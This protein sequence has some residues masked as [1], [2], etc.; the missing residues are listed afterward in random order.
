MTPSS[1]TGGDHERVWPEDLE[2]VTMNVHLTH[3]RHHDAD[4]AGHEGQA[5]VTPRNETMLDRSIALL[6]AALRAR[7]L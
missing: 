2:V 7:G 5:G 6:D 1:E 3:R 4:H